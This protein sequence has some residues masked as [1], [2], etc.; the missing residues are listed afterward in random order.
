[1]FVSKWGKKVKGLSSHPRKKVKV[2]QGNIRRQSNRTGTP[3][4]E[5]ESRYR[6]KRDWNKGPHPDVPER[7]IRKQ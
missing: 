1:M 7:M 5:M 4:L 6:E 3:V 2:P